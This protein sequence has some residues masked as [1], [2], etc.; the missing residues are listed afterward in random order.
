MSKQEA[1]ADGERQASPKDN[2]AGR[3]SLNPRPQIAKVSRTAFLGAALLGLLILT[4]LSFRYSR[5]SIAPAETEPARTGG[6]APLATEQLE[7]LTRPAEP[8]GDL[9]G[10]HPL[11]PLADPDEPYEPPVAWRP[12]PRPVRTPPPA[13]PP[14]RSAPL[15]VSLPA[16]PDRREP[17]Q[18]SPLA[19][20]AR[21]MAEQHRQLLSPG[22]GELAPG[23]VPGSAPDP[24][25]LPV[26][27]T[28]AVRVHL[29]PAPS[30]F[31]LHAGTYVPAVL[32]H[33]VSS[34]IGG[35]VRA[36]IT[37]DLSDSVTSRHWLIPRGTVVLGRQSRQPLAGERRLVIVWER[38]L[39][40]EG[41]SL[42]LDGEPAAGGDGTLGV[43]GRV[44]RRWGEQVR[45]AV[46]LSLVGAGLQLSQPQRSGDFSQAAD[47]GQVAAGAVGLELGRLS[48]RVLERLV[49]L[50]PTVTLSPGAR[51]H[52]LTTR[53]L[54]FDR[55]YRPAR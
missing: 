17:A 44:D 32:T 25:Q 39:L 43:P 33:T 38:L 8:S 20:A 42:D 47:P 6:A 3:V 34:E 14:G 22:A 49:D 41:Q 35:P 28:N 21:R 30:E 51:V 16:A 19:A 36:R 24:R 55:P 1:S 40:P 13:R 11:E 53:D 46:L 15:A 52:M 23:A 26:P 29:A 31:V 48:Q 9:F 50:P 54:V 4:V 45:T 37:E 5:E 7:R 27:E 18:S 10:A 12:P 2:G